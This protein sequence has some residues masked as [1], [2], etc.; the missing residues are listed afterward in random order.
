MRLATSFG[1]K[2]D[3]PQMLR[4]FKSPSMCAKTLSG[5]LKQKHRVL[6]EPLRLSGLGHEPDERGP[7]IVG[8]KSTPL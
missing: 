3:A 6:L 2:T 7:R 5:T 1:M 8:S 4:L